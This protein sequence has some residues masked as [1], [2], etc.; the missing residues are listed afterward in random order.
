MKE[1]RKTEGDRIAFVIHFATGCG[2][3]TH[4]T[5]GGER[6]M[7]HPLEVTIWNPNGVNG[8]HRTDAPVF[9]RAI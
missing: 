1:K 3:T 2:I 6:N 7:E 9:C 8:A 5:T 4:E